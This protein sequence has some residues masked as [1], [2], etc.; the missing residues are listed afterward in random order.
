MSKS[1]DFLFTHRYK[2]AFWF[3]FLLVI[4]DRWLL[5][6]HFTFRFVDDDQS[7]M[8]FGAKEYSTGNFHEPFFFGQNYNTMLESLFAIPLI[9][10]GIPYSV[11]LTVMM[12]LVTL[13][14]YFLLAIL[15]F[16][17]KRELQSLL[18]L[19]I[20]IL[21]PNEFGMVTAI[22]RGCAVGI[23]FVGFATLTLFTQNKFRFF[24]F[25]FTAMLGLFANPNAMLV[26]FPLGI[27]LLLENHSDR[28]FYFQTVLGAIPPA[29]IWYLAVH[30]YSV[31]P[32][33]IVHA[34]WPLHFSFASMKIASIIHFFND[35]VPVFWGMGWMIFVLL[36]F[37][38]FLLYRQ[39][40]KKS[41]V[42]LLAGI[43]LLVFSLGINKVNDGYPT[44]FYSWSRMFIGIPFLLAIFI[45][46]L[47]VD[48]KNNRAIISIL[49]LAICFFILKCST[50]S[51]AVHREVEEKKEH[52][53]FVYPVA[54][55]QTLCDTIHKVAQ[56]QH[57]ELIVIGDQYTKHLLN[58]G[59]PCME[60]NFPQT[61]EPALDRR[62][63][64]LKEEE[65]KIRSTVLFVAVY[66]DSFAEQL[67]R[68]PRIRKIS[69]DPLIYILKNNSL[70]TAALL[71]SL[72]L[73]LRAH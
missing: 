38:S 48:T 49:L 42:A 53:M 37:I 18:V 17:N 41:A 45:S 23:F 64:V 13:L 61:I 47:N 28:R 69:N 63:W 60:E 66:E 10:M 14:P 27:F 6:E 62:T 56:E 40:E 32:E 29:I 24:I 30:F 52:N 1:L 4:V 7:I 25:G 70:K 8:W 5:L 50:V 36:L 12:S 22:S 68:N 73:P 71:D 26:H 11:A 31:H 67:K 55:L 72:N 33:N 9:K 3:L 51:S 43:A 20:L 35:V 57:A 59:C 2:I 58:Y 54:S 65:N 19:S 44:V 46:R 15:L 34:S 16:R 21:L 39:K